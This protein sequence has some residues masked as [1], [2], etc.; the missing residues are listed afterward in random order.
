MKVVREIYS[1]TI[2]IKG[3][4]FISFLLPISKFKDELERLRLEHPK[5]VHFVSASRY[6]NEFDQIVESSSDDGEPRGTSGRPTLMVLQGGDIVNSAIITVRYFG[7]TK[8]GTGGLV[9]AYSDAA[10]AAIDSA[11]LDDYIKEYERVF[12]C[13][14]SDISMVEYELSQESITPSQK[15]FDENGATFIIFASIDKIDRLYKKLDRIIT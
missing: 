8:L 5:A 12:S 13:S 4:K 15:S 9:K 6:L 11:L 14:Y 3:S 7:G 10:N 1:D 2:E